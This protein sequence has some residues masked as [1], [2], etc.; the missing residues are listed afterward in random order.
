MSAEMTYEEIFKV[1]LSEKIEEYVPDG[2]SIS[3]PV[4]DMRN[5]HL[6]DCFLLYSLSRDQTKYTVPTARIIIDSENKKLV[7]YGSAEE[8]PFSV[9]NGTDYFSIEADCYTRDDTPKAEDEYQKLYIDVRKIAF[10]DM[11]SPEEKKI[12]ARYV[13]IL[14]SIEYE[15]L[16]PFLYELGTEFFRWVK[17]V[18]V[19]TK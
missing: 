16:V 12:V 17:R 5:G 2:I 1:L 13:K 10:K 14:K 8:L 19:S 4:L 7:E 18:L 15:H 6:V 9:Y 11:V 3:H